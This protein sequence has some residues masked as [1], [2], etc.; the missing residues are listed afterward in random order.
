MNTKLAIV[1]L[2]AMLSACAQHT[3][4][5]AV[6]GVGNV[7]APISGAGNATDATDQAP[8]AGAGS[9]DEKPAH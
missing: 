6:N 8:I 7:T 3:Y 5:A 9:A 1:S 2:A 4:P